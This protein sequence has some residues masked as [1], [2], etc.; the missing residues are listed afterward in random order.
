M[1]NPTRSSSGLLWTVAGA[2]ALCLVALLG[3]WW[4]GRQQGSIP[5]DPRRSALSEEARLLQGKV[6]RGEADDQQ[7]QRYLELLVGLERKSE[8]IAMLEPMADREP[9][10]WSLRLMLAELRR[11]QG[12]PAGAERELRQI[13]NRSPAQIDALQLLSL[14]RLEQGEAALAESQVKALY[15]GLLRPEVRDEAMGVGLLLAEL[16]QKRG[17]SRAAEATYQELS[18]AFPQDRRPLIALALL[19]HGRGNRAGALEALQQARSRNPQGA[20]DPRLDALAAS[21][22]LERLRDAAKPGPERPA[23]AAQPA[24]A[25]PPSSPAERGKLRPESGTAPPGP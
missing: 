22:G 8:A 12:D 4:L 14:I 17:E 7:R 10:R 1:P 18:Q 15:G 21:W 23:G 20:G 24:E 3:G 13:L 11:D 16:Q 25:S 6:V 19:R 9:E 2:T 5:V